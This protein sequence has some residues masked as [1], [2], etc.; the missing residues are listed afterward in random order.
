V[1]S[2]VEWGAAVATAA[3]GLLY[4]LVIVHQ[5]EPLEPVTWI[6]WGSV[7]LATAA[8]LLGRIVRPLFWLTAFIDLTW[9]LLAALSIGVTFVPGAVLAVAAARRRD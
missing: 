1:R 5:G 6:V 7:M 9:A 3:A 4:A 8:A 2:T